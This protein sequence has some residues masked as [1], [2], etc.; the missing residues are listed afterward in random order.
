MPTLGN[1]PPPALGHA[2][3]YALAYALLVG[4][5][6]GNEPPPALGHASTYALAY[7]L[8]VG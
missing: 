5:A 7:A 8:L 4:Y 1:E 2:S 3:T 6:I